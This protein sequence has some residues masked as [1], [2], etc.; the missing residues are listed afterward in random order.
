MT[1]AAAANRP[2]P[3]GV[4]PG[5]NAIQYVR[6]TPGYVHIVIEG[7]DEATVLAMAYQMAGCPNVTGPSAP[8]RTPGVD[9]VRVRVR[10]HLE[11]GGFTLP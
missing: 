1:S 5:M 3:Y 6:S 8:W 7:A 9:G 10:G 2:G 4:A 11:A